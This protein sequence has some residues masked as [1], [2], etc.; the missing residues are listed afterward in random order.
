MTREFLLKLLNTD[1]FKGK[2]RGLIFHLKMGLVGDDFVRPQLGEGDMVVT[3]EWDNDDYAEWHLDWENPR[4]GV[5]E[6]A[7]TDAQFSWEN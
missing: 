4:G 6:L 7:V 5:A 3:C 1:A 2:R